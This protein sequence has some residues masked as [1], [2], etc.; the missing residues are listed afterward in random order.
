ASRWTRLTAIVKTIVHATAASRTHH[1]PSLRIKTTSRSIGPP[2]M[3]AKATQQ[4]LRIARRRRRR[5]A[6]CSNR[7]MILRGEQGLR[8]ATDC[9]TFSSNIVRAEDDL[10][11][12]AICTTRPPAGLGFLN[13]FRNAGERRRDEGGV[14]DARHWPAPGRSAGPGEAEPI[15]CRPT[16][17]GPSAGRETATHRLDP[18]GPRPLVFRFG[19]RREA[20]MGKAK[21]K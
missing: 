7:T 18:G 20:G 6:D 2:I 15:G 4:R 1:P 16:S 12:R 10:K 9:D 8:D 11:I 17:A 5:S 13:S 19:I 3:M 14:T 21:A